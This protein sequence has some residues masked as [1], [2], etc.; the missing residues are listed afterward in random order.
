MEGYFFRSGIGCAFIA[1]LLAFSH[2]PLRAQS[3]SEADSLLL[4]RESALQQGRVVGDLKD[5]FRQHAGENFLL[6]PDNGDFRYGIVIYQIRIYPDKALFTAGIAFREPHSG[7]VAAFRARDVVFSYTHGLSGDATLELLSPLLFHLGRSAEIQLSPGPGNTYAV[8]ECKGLKSFSIVGNL[9]F[10]NT[11]MVPEKTDGT[12]D[13]DN[14]LQADFRFVA[15]RWND[16]LINLSLP[17]FQ[18]RALPG[19]SF[20]LQQC[21]LDLSETGNDPDVLF[22]PE[23]RQIPEAMTQGGAWEGVWMKAGRVKF[24]PWAKRSNAQRLELGVNGMLVDAWGFSGAIVAGQMLPFKEGELGGWAFSIDELRLRFAMNQ[25]KEGSMKGLL[26]M[27]LLPDTSAL[28]YSAAVSCYDRYAFAIQPSST[29]QFDALKASRVRLDPVSYFTLRLDSGKAT[30]VANMTGSMT[31]GIPQATGAEKLS[32]HIPAVQFQELRVSNREPR[33]DVSYLGYSRGADSS[34]VHNF[35]ISINRIGLRKSGVPGE[36]LLEAGLDIHLSEEIAGAVGLKLLFRYEKQGKKDRF[37]YQRTTLTE[38][39]LRA[40][41]AAFSLD[42]RLQYFSADVSY[43]QGFSGSIKLGIRQPRMEMGAMV[44]FGKMPEIKNKPSY[45]Y[46]FT[47]ASFVLESAGLPVF[48]GCDIN[49]FT[50]GAWRRVR[51][52]KPGDKAPASALGKGLSGLVYVPDADAGLG[53][54]A[55]VYLK[56]S[57]PSAKAYK[58][59]VVMEFQFWR[60][61]GLSSINLYGNAEILPVSTPVQKPAL[62]S[63]T[64][65]M[66]QVAGADAFLNAYKPQGQLAGAA[67]L[68]LD[69]RK[70]SLYG[71]FG[72]Y[73]NDIGKGAVSGN[74]PIG[75]AGEISLFFGETKWFV[76]AGTPENPLGLTVDAVVVKLQ[77]RS[78][79]MAGTEILPALPAPARV[80][81]AM[82]TVYLDK[83]RQIQAMAA[84]AGFAYGN[85]F[86]ARLGLDE[87]LLGLQFYSTV[88]MGVGSEAMLRDYGQKATC[89]GSAGQAG[90]KGWYA[91]GDLYAWMNVAIGLG[92]KSFRFDILN[93]VFASQLQWQGP[94]P[95][96]TRGAVAASYN[97]LGGL[98]R[99]RYTL[100]Y[101]L[102]VECV[103]QNSNQTSGTLIQSVSPGQGSLQSVYA[104]PVIEFTMPAETALEQPGTGKLLRL[105][106]QKAVV[107]NGSKT[108]ACQWF[109]QTES[110]KL[111]LK[112]TEVLPPN[113]TLRV[114]VVAALQSKGIYEPDNAWNVLKESGKELLETRLTEFT[115]TDQ[116]LEIPWSNV[117][118]TWPVKDQLQWFAGQSQ[119]QILLH[120]QQPAAT[121]GLEM[122]LTDETGQTMPA[123]P[124]KI[125][126]NTLNFDMPAGLKPGTIYHLVLRKG[127]SGTIPVIEWRFRTSTYASAADRFSAISI[128]TAVK[129]DPALG[130]MDVLPGIAPVEASFDKAEVSAG[131]PLLRVQLGNTTGWLTTAVIPALYQRWAKMPPDLA[132]VTGFRRDT[133]LLG[134]VPV[135]SIRIR[136]PWSD[137]LFLHTAHKTSKDI[138]WP[139][140]APDFAS[141]LQSE[142]QA[143]VQHLKE[144]LLAY[145]AANPGKNETFIRSLVATN[146]GTPV[147]TGT[148]TAGSAGPGMSGSVGTAPL[149]SGAVA[150]PPVKIP[151]LAL[152]KALKDWTVAPPVKNSELPVTFYYS[153]PGKPTEIF[154]QKGKYP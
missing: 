55:G 39:L 64:R 56:N 98:L 45:R 42:G 129:A 139:G 145:M 44:L 89:A 119:G 149:G 23:Y 48:P 85:E 17:A 116:R 11:L 37:V 95:F 73:V 112:P 47:D 63:Q 6:M 9:K 38:V 90:I 126:G 121:A 110:R 122:Q 25:L 124:V 133:S 115:T 30:L 154:T 106:I 148:A 14:P 51:Q 104:Q 105:H 34:R 151:D 140:Q 125:S 143:D 18:L 60:S 40:Q 32:Y 118:M 10:R 150:L 50:G 12:P 26:G 100:K 76:H 86:N 77:T 3:L 131:S 71:K 65:P 117:S 144:T 103:L 58:A 54:K 130:N 24:P 5:G 21:V 43:G 128:G 33:I 1:A 31:I 74:G 111:L 107:Q 99:G 113:A 28:R 146:A 61:G 120:Q 79:L 8:M 142:V 93:A 114:E 80:R 66:L 52:L 7:Q 84:G 109:W 67:F 36:F 137:S 152:L 97:V 46:W 96:Y 123:G 13:P 62:V 108:L 92:Y 102:G 49:G 72:L 41:T 78:Y 153:V 35:P 141:T 57:G 88:H 29:L 91:F 20:Q 87:K 101:K 82:G 134:F 135:K 94:N 75:R 83:L 53:L 136:Q 22:P 27:P 69:F 138:R 147:T 2:F 16:M 127:S 4:R 70:P 132:A 15:R 19:F 68:S 59:M 81:S